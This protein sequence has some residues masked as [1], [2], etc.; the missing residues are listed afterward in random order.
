[1]C[2]NIALTLSY[3]SFIVQSEIS[4]IRVFHVAIKNCMIVYFTQ[5]QCVAEPGCVIILNFDHSIVK[6]CMLFEIF[7]YS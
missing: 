5:C 4:S 7:L 3:F 6:N 1:M 2:V